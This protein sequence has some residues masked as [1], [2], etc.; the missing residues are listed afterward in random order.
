MSRTNSSAAS[1][2]E[3]SV[4]VRNVSKKYVINGSQSNDAQIVKHI[5]NKTTVDALRKVSFVVYGGESVGLIGLNGSGK[6]TILRMISGGEACTSGDVL[7][8]SQPTLLD[9][10]PA[11][12]GDLTGEQNIFL[13]CLAVGMSPSEA[14]RQIPLI[15]EWTQLGDA[16]KRPM[17]T[18]SSGM[19]SRL[20]FAIATAVDPDILL[21]DEALSTGDS[22]FSI[23][24]RKRMESLL[25]RA[26]NLF[27]VSHSIGTVEELCSRSIWLHNGKVIAD[28]DTQEVC[29]QY[30]E[31]GRLLGKDDKSLAQNYL[32]SVVEG[33]REPIIELH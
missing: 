32:S 30:H 31:W 7:V 18:Y 22:A 16:M 26:G 28:G 21:I 6:S 23:R 3:I 12:Q 2:Q 11:L 14:K 10:A 9:V 25:Q 33:Y 20:S 1:E 27:L 8:R 4:I 24:A 17:L 13:G 19:R 15:T 29:P 5:G